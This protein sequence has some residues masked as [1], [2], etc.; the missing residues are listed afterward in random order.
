MLFSTIAWGGGNVKRYSF[1]NSYLAHVEPAKYLST[2]D[3]WYYS[4][5]TRLKTSSGELE[6]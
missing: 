1:S 4:H 3:D 5:L 2:C 6:Y